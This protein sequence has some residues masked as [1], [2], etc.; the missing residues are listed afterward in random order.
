M[1]PTTIAIL[2]IVFFFLMIFSGIPVGF[3]LPIASLAGLFFIEG[4]KTT[5]SVTSSIF[6]TYMANYTM[7][8]IPAFV[9]MGTLA[10]RSGIL[11][12][13]FDAIEMWVGRLPGGLAIGTIASNAIF[14]AASG[15]IIS[16]CTVIGRSAIPKMRKAGYPDSRSVGVV[17]ASGTLSSLIPP[18]IIICLYGLIVSQSIGKLLMAGILPG[19]ISAIFYMGY[20]TI[21]SRNIAKLAKRYTWRQKIAAV[22]YLWIAGLIL[23]FVMGSIYFGIATPTEAGAVGAFSMFILSLITG[24][25]TVPKFIDAIW[26]CV[27]ISGMVLFLIV[28]AAFFGRLLVVSTLSQ[29]I[30]ESLTNAELNRYLIFFFVAVI[31]FILGMIIDAAG[32]MVISLPI[33]FP[34][35]TEL[36]FD[37]IWLGIICIKFCEMA[38]ITPPV[39]MS[40]YA[41]QSVSGGVPL[42]T[43]F[44]GASRFLMMD[45]FTVIFLTVFPQIILF[46]PN[47]M[48]K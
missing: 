36:G 24:K 46:L 11:D 38:L 29:T 13:V 10:Y 9:F 14:A 6:T 23:L 8:V 35:M 28:A 7:S 31:W 44:S 17:A 25:L 45:I 42:S 33:V 2:S 37:P 12:D 40:V 48:F 26:D 15:S 34:V 30:V 22:R 39:G 41:T 27:S 1:E 47:L 21:S 5:L 20:I 4:W 32:M 18:S 43:S 3:G 16:A 19:I